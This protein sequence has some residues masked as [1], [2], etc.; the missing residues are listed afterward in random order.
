MAESR[1]LHA[2]TVESVCTDLIGGLSIAVTSDGDAHTLEKQTSRAVLAWYFNNRAKWTGN[3]TIPDA[4]AIVDAAKAKP[5]VIAQ[6]QSPAEQSKRC[7]T[8]IKVEAHHFGGLH[9]FSDAGQPPESFI[10]EPAKP[11][12]L[13]EGWNGS[14]KTSVLNAVIWCLTG[15]VLRP[16]RKPE[17]TEEEFVCRIQLDASAPPTE[18][19]L[20]PVTPLPNKR[21]PPDLS[22][23]RL[24]LDTWVELTFAD[25]QGNV[26]P[27]IR[28]T[29][30]RTAKGAVEESEADIASMGLDPIAANIGTTIPG[31]L[32]FIQIGAV[33]EFGQA[34]AQLTGLADLVDLAKHATRVQQRI[35]KEFTNSR[36]EEI[37]QQNNAFRQSRT[38]LQTLF[39]ETPSL[40]TAG[41]LPDP[42][43]TAKLEDELI[44]IEEHLILCKTQALENAKQ[45]LGTAFDAS[46]K[47]ARNSLEESV[48]PAFQQ[49]NEFKRLNSAARLSGLGDLT[50]VQ[51]ADALK[52]IQQ[53]IDEGKT[54]GVLMATP[55]LAKRRQLYGRVAAW[56]KEQNETDF[57]TCKV[58]GGDLK[59]AVDPKSGRLVRDELSDALAAD[60]ELIGHTIDS[61]AASRLGMLSKNLPQQLALEIKRELPPAPTDLLISAI[62]NELFDAVPFKGALAI[63]K[64]DTRI[65]AES[66]FATL[67]V[68]ANPALDRLPK[69]I[70]AEVQE[71]DDALSRIQR[72]I[73]FGQW[74]KTN[75]AAINDAVLAVITKKNPLN[76][77]VTQTSPLGVKLAALLDTVKS[78]APIN[79]ALE[80]CARMAKSLKSRREKE[81]RIGEYQ[82]A[83]DALKDI[84]AIG[85]LVQTQVEEL[86]K[87]L[88]GRAC[89]W[90]NKIYNNAYST[91]GYGL[92]GSNM[93]SKGTL[94]LFVGS[95]GVSAPAQ[96]VSNASALR[97][98][99]VGFYLAFWEHVHKERGGLKLLILDD[100]QELL[101]D[102]NRDRMARTFPEVVEAGA[103]LLLTTHNRSFAR[104]SVAEAR[105]NDLVEHR[106]VHPVNEMRAT[107]K[108]APAIEELDR[109]REVFER[110]IDDAAKAQDYVIEARAFIEE[111]LADLFDDPAYPAYSAPSKAP[112]FGDYL[113]RLRS[114]V[115]TPPN[116]LF[117]R[118]VVLDL[119]SDVALKEGAAC[120]TLLNK[121]HHRDKSKISYKD[122]ADQAENL[123][124]LRRR[125]EDVHEE[126]RRWKWRDPSPSPSNVVP[127]KPA[128]RPTFVVD[129]HP[130]LA[131]FTGASQGGFQDEPIETF[132]N[133]WFEN[134]SFFYLKN[135][136]MG[137]AAPATSIVVVESD[138]K[139]G[140][141][142]NLVIAL[143]KNEVLARRLLRPRGDTIALALAAQ[144]PDPRKSPPTRVLDPG[145]VQIHRV[146][147]VL[148][149]NLPPPPG[150]EEAVQ[151]YDAPSL[152]RIETSYRVRDD[153]ALPLALP[154]QIVLGGRAILP[155]EL[156]TYEGKFVAL[157]LMDGS[158]IFKRIGPML[159]GLKLLR[160]FESIGGLGKSEVI[161]TE[162]VEGEFADLRVM[163][164]AREI[165]GVIYE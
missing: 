135:E 139:P 53:I 54:L 89:Y 158:S 71:V 7:L 160:Q 42:N 147:G 59:D 1:P 126:F 78:V 83:S 162:A 75:R 119:C 4:D 61:W 142:R 64:P 34:I 62:A 48:L 11:I 156:D 141:D 16:Q 28:R 57:S 41:E 22:R 145:E 63:L 52:L 124:R 102:D 86:R 149:D 129:I 157:T 32:P 17:E 106:S 98:S 49:L 40:K 77:P 118:K 65:L 6:S 20:T 120:V 30:K 12:T 95:N 2:H 93:D 27:S 122:V 29:Q 69:P 15:Q 3:V 70:S 9:S 72:A 112:S 36:K 153:S 159:P 123:R 107:V 45:V 115:S 47:S 105:K 56:M 136:N 67:P 74:Q 43:G 110:N 44:A 101:D 164:F 165:L 13:L 138:S 76:L 19:K 38:D 50:D 81:K 100:P 140:N 152:K 154:G 108:T 103:Q 66:C 88:D 130:D 144:T 133:G 5:P 134:K 39:D 92:V 55:D 23:E 8:L 68:L 87:N 131:A 18:H 96:H 132:D 33:S 163:E 104:M 161:A 127:L 109:K 25:H 10:F 114:L 85:T 125:I 146:L 97:A 137:F 117:R 58:C 21:F 37:Q 26:L 90:R 46:D 91:S 151:I 116:E 80:Y 73:S 111:R 14:G 148:F 113:A 35:D 150:K 128:S 60:S 84:I 121:A 24:P 31:L 94:S 99:L 143:Y 82:A 155:S 79:S 51:I